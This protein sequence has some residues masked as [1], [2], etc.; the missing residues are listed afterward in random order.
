[1]V[2]P[3]SS[4]KEVLSC[5]ETSVPENQRD[6][7]FTILGGIH[8]LILSPRSIGLSEEDAANGLEGYLHVWAVVGRLLGME[9]KFNIALNYSRETVEKYF[10]EIFLPSFAE[11]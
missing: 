8:I 10:Q 9:D 1:L 6:M 2:Q 4:Y 11:S 7:A 3:E 5:W